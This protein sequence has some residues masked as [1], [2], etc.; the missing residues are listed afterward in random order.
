MCESETIDADD[1]PF[2]AAPQEVEP[3]KLMIPGVTMAEIERYAIMRTLESVG[4]ST[5]KAA[6]ILG[7]SRRTIQYRLKQWGM[8]RAVNDESV[9]PKIPSRQ[10]DAPDD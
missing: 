5:S 7:I 1:L 4:G 9:P 3:L 2:G 10:N 8:T 6:A